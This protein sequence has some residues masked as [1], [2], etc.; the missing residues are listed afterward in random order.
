MTHGD[1]VTSA[2]FSPDGKR[3]VTASWDYH[4]QLW[5]AETGRAV[6]AP[7]THG[8]RITSAR[9]SPDGKWVVTASI[10]NSHILECGNRRP[11]GF[12]MKHD[13]AIFSAS[14]SPDGKRVVTASKDENSPHLGSGN[15]HGRRLA[16]RRM[17]T[18]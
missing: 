1:R 11:V 17:A 9:F 7:M 13:Q 8:D 14:F 6:G 3:V 15:R 5:D 12:P 2:R 10:D 4:G 16:D 18:W